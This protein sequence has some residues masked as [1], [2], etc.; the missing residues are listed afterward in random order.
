M[1]LLE[2]SVKNKKKNKLFG[3]WLTDDLRN[4]MEKTANLYR[5]EMRSIKS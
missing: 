1:N 2:A 5:K 3:E 4:N